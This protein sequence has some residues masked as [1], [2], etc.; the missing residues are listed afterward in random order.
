MLKATDVIVKEIPNFHPL[1][2]DYRIFWREQRRRCIEGM[3]AS[4]TFIPPA[5]YY[6][7]NFHTIRLNKRGSALKTFDRP[8][9]RDVEYK[10]FNYY[11]EARGFS[12]F[13]DDHYYSSN[14]VL[15]DENVTD[16]ILMR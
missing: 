8:W 4:G 14:N 6:Y 3:W 12:G 2:V 13:Q 5:L 10:F 15:L 16:D 1:S 11:T 9:L 7:V